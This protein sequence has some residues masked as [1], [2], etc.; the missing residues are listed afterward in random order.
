[1][2]SQIDPTKPVDDI[3]AIRDALHAN[4]QAAKYKIEDVQ[5]GKLTS[6]TMLRWP[7]GIAPIVSSAASPV[8]TYGFGTRDGRVTWF[9]FPAGKD[10]A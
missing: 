6:P 10:F 7:S 5:V 2:A 4:L 3:P 8:D 1:M 9:A